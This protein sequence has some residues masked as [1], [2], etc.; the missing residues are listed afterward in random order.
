MSYYKAFKFYENP[1]IITLRAN[2]FD[3]VASWLMFLGDLGMS[4]EDI[5]TDLEKMDKSKMLQEVALKVTAVAGK[6][7]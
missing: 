3:S 7:K 6:K 5:G 4:K 1:K 2:E